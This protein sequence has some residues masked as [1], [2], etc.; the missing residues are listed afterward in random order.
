MKPLE[1]VTII[2]SVTNNPSISQASLFYLCTTIKRFGLSYDFYDLSGTI[3]YDNPPL[4]LFSK[5]DSN[6]WMNLRCI[7]AGDWMD[8]LISV[9][10]NANKYIFFSAL[11]SPDLLIHSRISYK[12]KQ[13]YNSIT[14]I[15]GAALFGLTKEQLELVGVFFDYV[16]VGYDIENLIK[17]VLE[18]SNQRY[19]FLFSPPTY[20]PD[21][22]LLPLKDT[23]NIYTGHGC[24]YGK[25]SFCDYPLR[26][27]ISIYFKD[28][29]IV[30]QEIRE[31]SEVKPNVKEIIL[32]QDSYT[33]INL[34][35]TIESI[36][37]L[38]KKI[39]IPYSLMLKSEKWLNE[40]LG[41]KLYE[42]NCSD[43][44]IGVEAL[45]DYILSKIEKG[46]TVVDIINAIRTLSK[47]VEIYIGMI[48][49]I[50]NIDGKSLNTQLKNLEKILPFVS[51][52]EPEVLT[53]VNGSEL[54]HRA[55]QEGIIL[56]ATKNIINRSWCFGLS[57]DIP[58]SFKNI[59][60]MELWFKHIVE[61][62]KL[63]GAKIKD[64]YWIEVERIKKDLI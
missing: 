60:S 49:F 1:K 45:D 20:S 10:I 53:I 11:F 19:Y 50:P 27:N 61:F 47:Y 33:K 41:K 28:P 25:C 52:I 4:E 57:H 56:N 7:T 55:L 36:S 23:V 64:K 63:S 9:D 17:R 62:E 44:F 6:L 8:D 13:K 26:S 48:L 2:S 3:D 29:N 24:Y 40:D 43:I 51:M 35:N 54:Y 58:W 18:K 21:Y 30:S 38:D 39:D 59:Q 14:A 22:K 12:L 32:T 31:I 15:G 34:H 37:K 46:I 42:S 16:L 5:C